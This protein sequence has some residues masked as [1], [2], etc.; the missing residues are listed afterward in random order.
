[1]R[2]PI[3]INGFHAPADH[4]RG[5]ERRTVAFAELVAGV[6][7]ALS[8]M[9]VATVLSVGVARANVA[10]HVIGHEGSL[11]GIALLL[12]LIFIGLGGISALP[13]DKRKKY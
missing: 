1:M 11:F 12:G 6:A 10:D 7:L 3:E 5:R 9:V 2:K 4:G 13:D 8:T